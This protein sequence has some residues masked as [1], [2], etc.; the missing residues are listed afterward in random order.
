MNR[1][2]RRKMRR[3]A[4]KIRGWILTAMAIMAAYLVLCGVGITEMPEWGPDWYPVQVC[5]VVIGGGWLTMFMA[6]NGAFD[7]KKKERSL[8][9]QSIGRSDSG[10]AQSAEWQLRICTASQQLA[11][12]YRE[13]MAVVTPNQRECGCSTGF[14]PF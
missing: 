14:R 8:H 11:H 2:Q 1:K 5:M 9:G 13:K 3:I 10:R 6:A 4:G 12:R 7:E